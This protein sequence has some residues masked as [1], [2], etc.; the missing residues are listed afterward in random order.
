MTARQASTIQYTSLC[1]TVHKPI[2]ALDIKLLNYKYKY[3]NY[4]NTFHGLIIS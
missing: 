2:I 4:C 1:H 3:L